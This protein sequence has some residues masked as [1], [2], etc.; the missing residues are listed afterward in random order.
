MNLDDARGSAV[1]RAFDAEGAADQFKRLG[2]Q[3][4]E[5]GKQALSILLQNLKK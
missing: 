1:L 2:R 4:V 3:L 5:G